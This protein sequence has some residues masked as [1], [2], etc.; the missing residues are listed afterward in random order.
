MS[1]IIKIKRGAGKPA[2]GVLKAGE[3][4]F[5]TTNKNLYIGTDDTDSSA[6]EKIGLGLTTAEY[7]ELMD[8][9]NSI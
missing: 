6:A 3:L 5:D 9:I 2:N 8:L 7:Q 4:G 1:N